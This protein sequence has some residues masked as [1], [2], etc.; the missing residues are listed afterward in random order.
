VCVNPLPR[1][2]QDAAGREIGVQ[3]C[4]YLMPQKAQGFQGYFPVSEVLPSARCHKRLMR[5]GNRK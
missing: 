2:I 4:A 3:F 1:I 5:S